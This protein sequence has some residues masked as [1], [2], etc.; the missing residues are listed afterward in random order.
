VSK[1]RSG[2]G[3]SC[4]IALA[5]VRSIDRTW[6]APHLTV[7]NRSF[8]SWLT[9]RGSLTWRLRARCRRLL[10]ILLRQQLARP[11]PDEVALLGLRPGQRA[12]VREV[13]LLADDQP[14]LYAHSVT[15][16]QSLRAAW[17]PLRGLGL[18]PAGDAIFARRGTWRGPIRVRRLRTGD[19]LHRAAHVAMGSEAELLPTLWAR[20]SPFVHAGQALWVTEVF[21][22][23]I[24]QLATHPRDGSFHETKGMG[25][26]RRLD[27]A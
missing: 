24:A 4:T 25:G 19:R 2:T 16:V 1:A 21:L 20:R 7:A 12:W 11:L 14:V 8:A 6:R 5:G 3:A 18:T 10:L 17:R 26:H 9:E 27:I 13:L 22:P 23:A 15:C